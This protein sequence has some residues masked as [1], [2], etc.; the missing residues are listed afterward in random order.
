MILH[1]GYPICVTALK[2]ASAS[3]SALGFELPI[4]SEARINNRLAMN[5]GSSPASIMRAS[6]YTAALGS[7]P[8]IDFI[9]AEI[10]SGPFGVVTVTNHA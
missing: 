2:Q 6:Q 7:L 8:R 3:K 10:I 4:S 5:L 9:K 1:S